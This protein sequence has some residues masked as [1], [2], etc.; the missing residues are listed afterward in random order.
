MNELELRN[1]WGSKKKWNRDLFDPKKVAMESDKDR[2]PKEGNNFGFAFNDNNFS[3][4]VL[5]I[6]I[7]AEPSDAKCDG[8][9]CCSLLDWARH[10]KRRRED[11][12]KDQGFVFHFSFWFS[13]ICVLNSL[14]LVK[15]V[16][17]MVSLLGGSLGF[18][19][20]GN[21]FCLIVMLRWFRVN[22]LSLGKLLLL[23]WVFSSNRHLSHFFQM[24]R[25][26][27]FRK[28]FFLFKLFG[29]C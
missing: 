22:S 7:M 27:E 3:D 12:K 10:R 1:F 20:I 18:F 19:L 2:S 26:C 6:E 17:V 21:G 8:D 4:R 24:G 15:I 11:L 9:G 13:S 28:C 14:W 23:D 29:F 16:F 5:R 25:I